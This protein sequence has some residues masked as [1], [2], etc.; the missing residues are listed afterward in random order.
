MAKI[1]SL[2][3]AAGSSSRMGSNKLLFPQGDTTVIE[4][5]VDFFSRQPRIDEVVIVTSSNE[6]RAL[7]GDRFRI[8]AGGKE[9]QDSVWAGLH[10]LDDEDYVLIHDGARPFL[11]QAALDRCLQMA[12][13]NK[14]FCL[15]VPVTDTLKR[16][17]QGIVSTPDRS[18]FFAAQTPQG[19]PVLLLKEAY[20]DAF[21]KGI[22]LTDDASALERCGH[23][24]ELVAGEYSNRKL[25]T[26]E[27]TRYL[28][29][30]DKE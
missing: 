1:I 27:D 20:A 7:L 26:P 18:E 22:I 30:S 11:T 13:R 29:E 28:C 5:V 8:V 24:V 3:M 2:I 19:A 12:Q 4:A 14:P 16:V 17:H 9:R 23:S 21:A 25:T 15:A 6:I 10:A